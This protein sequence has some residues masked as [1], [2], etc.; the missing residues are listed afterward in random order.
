M[1]KPLM[2]LGNGFSGRANV[3]RLMY[4]LDFINIRRLKTS[5]FKGIRMKM[6]QQTE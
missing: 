2:D 5:L 6:R 4:L 1:K 3:A